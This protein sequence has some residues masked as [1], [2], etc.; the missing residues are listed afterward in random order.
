[1]MPTTATTAAPTPP[2]TAMPTVIGSLLPPLPLLPESAA[3]LAAS[4][5]CAADGL[6]AAGLSVPVSAPA[7]LVGCG[8]PGSVSRVPVEPELERAVVTV[9]R[10]PVDAVSGGEV[11]VPCGAAVPVEDA[12]VVAATG[13]CRS[14][15]WKLI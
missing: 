8:A 11:D 5:V 1:M 7:V 4:L 14:L 12:G 2:P 10:V 3:A 9:A 6:S 15:L 13:C